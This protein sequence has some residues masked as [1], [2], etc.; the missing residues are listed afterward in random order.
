M[1][2]GLPR[3]AFLALGASLAGAAW[4]GVLA[5]RTAAVAEL[6]IPWNLGL[7]RSAFLPLLGKTFRIAHD[8]GSLTVVLSQICDLDP[9]VRPGAEDQFSLIFTDARLRPAIPQGTYSV[10][11]GR[12]GRS[13]F[14]VPV[15]RRET[16]QHYQAVIDCR[17]L[18]SIA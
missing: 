2:V 10:T 8:A 6:A 14:V 5:P 17:P 9:T 3:R 16:A 11:Q 12:R 18:A 4:A 1:S 7:R 15:G 13:L